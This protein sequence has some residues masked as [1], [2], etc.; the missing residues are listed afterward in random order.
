MAVFAADVGVPYASAQS[1]KGRD[2]INPIYW[3]RIIRAAER[4]G[5][6]GVTYEALVQ[7]YAQRYG[8]PVGNA[9]TAA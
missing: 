9:L 7:M 8:G 6:D 4:R 3:P 1:M 2:A 5:V